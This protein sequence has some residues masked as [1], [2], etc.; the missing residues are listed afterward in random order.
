VYWDRRAQ[1]ATPSLRNRPL[2]L[3][4]KGETFWAQSYPSCEMMDVT[5]YRAKTY[6]SHGCFNLHWC[7][8][9]LNLHM[10]LARTVPRLPP[11]IRYRSDESAAVKLS[12]P[13]R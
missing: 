13:R 7:A 3:S 8:S 2:L 9:P 11:A 5:L 6:P 12:G 4:A 10:G 1:Q